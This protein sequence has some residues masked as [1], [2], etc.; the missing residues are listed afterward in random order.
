MLLKLM[1][2]KPDISY[3]LGS[4]LHI[5]DALSR[6]HPVQEHRSSKSSDDLTAEMDIAIHSLVANLPMFEA[7]LNQL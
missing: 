7:R 1:R 3:V 6:A 5:T 4:K 2:Y